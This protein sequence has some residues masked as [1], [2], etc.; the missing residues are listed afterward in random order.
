MP[1]GPLISGNDLRTLGLDSLFQDLYTAQRDGIDDDIKALYATVDA[2]TNRVQFAALFDVPVP[3]LWTPGDGIPWQAIDSLT[4][5]INVLKFAKALPWEIDDEEDD[6][7]GAIPARV[8]DLAGEFAG[9]P[10]R[11]AVD[12]V[13]A[14]ASLLSSVP[15]AYDGSP[16]YLAAPRFG[17]AGGN[18]IGGSGTG[19]PGAIQSDFYSLKARMKAFK[20]S[21][22]SAE[23]F[24]MGSG[25]DEHKNW[26]LVF[27]ADA[28]GEQNARTAFG[29]NLT[30]DVTGLGAVG[31]VLSGNMPRLKFWSRLSGAD[32]FGFYTGS[33]SRKPFVMAE[34]HAAPVM[35]EFTEGTSDWSREFDRRGI[36]WKQRVAF[37]LFAPETTVRVDN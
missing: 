15:A 35:V 17:V 2:K 4:H 7:L 20:R 9:L 12:L 30:I 10:I 3:E 26:L 1:V 11:A 22:A 29:A 31:N 8:Q 14:T 24:W 33:E 32:W 36:G 5:T 16:L 37:G 21:T 18:S 34:R 6:Q 23:P 27:S 28:A 25:L 19:S 13:T